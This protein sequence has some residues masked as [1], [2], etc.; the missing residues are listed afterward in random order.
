M[1][2]A[3][4]ILTLALIAYQCAKDGVWDRGWRWQRRKD[5]PSLFWTQIILEISAAIVLV[6]AHFWL[7][8]SL[9]R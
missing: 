7:R 4:A 5:N 2:L 8:P 1:F 3:F 6:G 9:F